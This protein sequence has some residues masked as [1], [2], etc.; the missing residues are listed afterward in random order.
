[1]SL[2]QSPSRAAPRHRQAPSVSCAPS[3]AR[4]YLGTAEERREAPVP[5]RARPPPSVRQRPSRA[6]GGEEGPA[7]QRGRFPSRLPPLRSERKTCEKLRR[8]FAG[9]ALRRYLLMKPSP[10]PSQVWKRR[11]ILSSSPVLEVS[12]LLLAALLT[13]AAAAAAIMRPAPEEKV[14]LPQAPGDPSPAAP[15]KCG[16]L[17]KA[18][19]GAGSRGARSRCTPT[20]RAPP[21]LRAPTEPGRV[22]AGGRGDAAPP[23]HRPR[24]GRH[25]AGAAGKVWRCLSLLPSFRRPLPHYQKS[26]WSVSKWVALRK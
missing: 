9:A 20:H 17:H 25:P 13:S 16:R 26:C 14:R 11:L 4:S 19:A 23:K 7:W 1:M 3:G 5:P 21:A 2:P 12:L 6:A 10:S 18:S 22:P 15:A 24:S 8:H